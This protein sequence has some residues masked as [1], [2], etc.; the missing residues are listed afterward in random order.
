MTCILIW[1]GVALTLAWPYYRLQFDPRT[2]KRGRILG[3]IFLALIWPYGLFMVARKAYLTA[4]ITEWQ[5]AR[6]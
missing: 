2:P 1:Q 6:G 3:A 4:T 5:V